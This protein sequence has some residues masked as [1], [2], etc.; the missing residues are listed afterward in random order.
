MVTGVLDAA[1]DG[2]GA[3]GGCSRTGSVD[4][5]ATPDAGVATTIGAGVSA[6]VGG[7]VTATTGGGAGGDGGWAAAVP[8]CGQNFAATAIARLHDGQLRVPAGAASGGADVARLVPH[9]RQ[10]FA[11]ARF[12]TLHAEHAGMMN[13]VSAI[14]YIDMSFFGCGE[15]TSGVVDGMSLPG[16]GI[17]VGACVS[18]ALPF[19]AVSDG[20]SAGAATR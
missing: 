19:V 2:G 13:L 17:D 12:S 10:N 1:I 20:P 18:G 7:G 3:I 5:S 14:V 6:T 9:A 15:L 8:Q 11:S 16:C 4:A